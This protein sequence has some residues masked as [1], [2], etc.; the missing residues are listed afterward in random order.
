[1]KEAVRRFDEAV[2]GNGISYLLDLL[3][4]KLALLKR[5][6]AL[7]RG[8]KGVRGGLEE[9]DSPLRRLLKCRRVSG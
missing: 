7:S 6:G 4:R 3:M 5:A 2:K 9:G 1:M 8:E